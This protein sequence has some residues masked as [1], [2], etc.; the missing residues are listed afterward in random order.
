MEISLS[1]V[2][3]T[4]LFTICMA[5]LSS[6]GLAGSL[7]IEGT[8]RINGNLDMVNHQIKGVAYP[9]AGQDAASKSYV[10]DQ[11]GTSTPVKAKNPQK[12]ALLRWYDINLAGV[13]VY[14]GT[15]TTPG[16][17]AF[18]GENI[19]VA[20]IGTDSIGIW[21]ASDGKDMGTFTFPTVCAGVAGLAYDGGYIWVS[22][23]GANEVRVV[24][25]KDQSYVPFNS[26]F[27]VPQPGAIVFDGK[28][29]W[30]ASRGDGSIRVIDAGGRVEIQNIPGSPATPVVEMASDGSRMW[31][32]TGAASAFV[33]SLSNPGG[34]SSIFHMSD[35]GA[36]SLA[37]DGTNMWITNAD[38][39][40]VTVAGPGLVN[41]GEF[42]VG[43]QPKDLVFDGELMWVANYEGNSVSLFRT[44]DLSSIDTVL[45]GYRPVDTVFDG[46]N[47]WITDYDGNQVHKH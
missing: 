31:V 1:K 9:V 41:L 39:D 27:S 35:A 25:A 43:D 14:P 21:R 30:V 33:F 13:S 16:A 26:Q 46:A 23:Q 32:T 11:L 19:W 22:C 18:D 42:G 20:N 10:D 29:M 37:F 40:T 4:G 6:Q 12:V 2:F 38:Q 36:W 15:G 47:V 45:L 5:L 8:G 44:S 24:S 28:N 34:G 17:I 3:H 7:N